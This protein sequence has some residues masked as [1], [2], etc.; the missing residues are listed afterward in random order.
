MASEGSVCLPQAFHGDRGLAESDVFLGYYTDLVPSI[1]Q[2]V[3]LSVG[4]NGKTGVCVER[5]SKDTGLARGQA[6]RHLTRGEVEV[7]VGRTTG[8]SACVGR[9]DNAD[10]EADC[11][12]RGVVDLPRWD[13][14]FGQGVCACWGANECAWWDSSFQE[15]GERV[16]QVPVHSVACVFTVARSV[17]VLRRSGVTAV[18]LSYRAGSRLGGRIV[19]K[20][21]QE[22]VFCRWC[23][24]SMV[25]DVD[26]LAGIW[27][28]AIAGGDVWCATPVPLSFTVRISGDA[29]GLCATVSVGVVSVADGFWPV[30]SVC[31]HV[32]GGVY[33]FRVSFDN[34][35]FHSSSNVVYEF[36]WGLRDRVV[37]GCKRAPARLHPS[38]SFRTLRHKS[39]GAS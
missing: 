6:D 14:E 22:L 3:E 23:R 11:L 1:A 8:R 4:D 29:G 39:G 18:L 35:V 2:L 12:R 25:G 10:E 38:K 16:A 27:S 33:R 9:A 32:R 31:L 34:R 13:D 21:C 37:V 28:R 36:G 24:T 15:S 17:N 5:V 30:F 26:S 20:D 19:D 7:S